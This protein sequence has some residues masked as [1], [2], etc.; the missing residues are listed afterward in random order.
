VSE[1]DH[2]QCIDNGDER[3]AAQLEDVDLLLVT[4][5][6]GVTGIRQTNERD[7]LCSPIRA[8]RNSGVGTY[9]QHNGTAAREDV[10]VIPQARQLRAAVWSEESAQKGQNDRLAT[11]VSQPDLSPL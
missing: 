10:I 5:R 9:C 8:E 4:L 1:A 7:L 3:H 6:N 2:A 11:I